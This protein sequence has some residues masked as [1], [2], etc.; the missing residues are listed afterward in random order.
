MTLFLL[1]FALRYTAPPPDF[2][3]TGSYKMGGKPYISPQ[4]VRFGYDGFIKVKLIAPGRIVVRL[5]AHKLPNDHDG[6]FVDTLEY[7]HHRAVYHHCESDTSCRIVF[8]FT[9][10]GVSVEQTQDNL[11]YG[12]GFGQG[13]FA[14]G[15]YKKISAA[16]PVITDDN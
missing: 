4:G 9:S 15:D 1:L 6:S 7:S 11:N 14:N 16:V 5:Y 10:K 8:E 2:N 12:C 13:V 3:P